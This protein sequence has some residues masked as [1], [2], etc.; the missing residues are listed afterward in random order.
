MSQIFMV[1]SRHHSRSDVRVDV[2]A[3]GGSDDG[4]QWA[5]RGYG[6]LV[7]GLPTLLKLDKENT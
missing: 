3:D 4:G 2:M 1:G 5:V 6:Y 7:G